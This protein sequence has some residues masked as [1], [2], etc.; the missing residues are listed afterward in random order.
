M[1]IDKIAS[2]FGLDRSYIALVAHTA[3][4]RY[5]TYQIPKKT[6]GFRTINHP[7][8][9][10]KLL[11]GWLVENVFARFPVHKSATAYKKGSSTLLNATLHKKHN[12]VLKV[13]FE[14]FFPSITGTDVVR[15]LRE[16]R[17]LTS[18]TVLEELD[19][20]LVRRIVCRQD[21]LTIGAPSSP[22]ISNAVMFEF[23]RRQW[24][25]CHERRIAY[26]RY[27]DDL[28]FSTDKRDLLGNLLA[29]LREYLARRVSP[30]LRINERKTVFTS[31]KR[32]RLVT[33]LVLT[34]SGTVSL[35]RH[36]KRFIKSLTFKNSMGALSGE[37]RLSLMG[38]VAYAKSIEPAFVDSLRNKY[39]AKAIGEE[40]IEAG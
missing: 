17:H 16:H 15:L 37:Q 10:L 36:R 24:S 5:K 1:L 39:G 33:G 14:D 40:S 8:R 27:A 11:Q 22:I 9:E 25:Y 30:V 31:R 34:S 19:V 28:Y 3:S 29:D 32:R 7:A 2:S 20:E 26:S 23:D 21:R 4:H 13:D 18:K 35:G 38:L 6:G 12:Y